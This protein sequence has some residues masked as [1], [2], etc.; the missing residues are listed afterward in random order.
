MKIPK[1]LK[2]CGLNYEVLVDDNLYLDKG[3]T[4]T[5][6]AE[7]LVIALHTQGVNDQRVMQTFLHE[8]I[9]AV[10]EHFMGASLS[11]QQVN[12]FAAG[13]YQVLVDNDLL[14]MEN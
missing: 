2:I 5:H 6:H 4:G 8:V 10:D 14:K 9:H 1:T 11:E 12:A 13:L 7:K 3:A